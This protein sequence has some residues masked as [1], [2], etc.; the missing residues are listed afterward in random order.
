MTTIRTGEGSLYDA[1]DNE[2]AP[3]AYLIEG[4]A[5][6]DEPVV[7]WGGRLT[8]PTDVGELSLD[9]GRYLLQFEGG[10]RAWIALAPTGAAAGDELAFAGASVLSTGTGPEPR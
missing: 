4:E 10:S 5:E 3:V 9:P 7:A 8:L 6:A 2:L 1:D